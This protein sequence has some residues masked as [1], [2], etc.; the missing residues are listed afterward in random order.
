M[1]FLNNKND[2]ILGIRFKYDISL[3][4]NRLILQV[5]KVQF[6]PRSF[7]SIELCAFVVE[8]QQD[9]I[10]DGHFDSFLRFTSAHY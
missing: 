10:K 6:L 1:D 4:V 2:N 9:L 5:I 7:P 8:T 3:H